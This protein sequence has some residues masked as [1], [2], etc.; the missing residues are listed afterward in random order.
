MK[1][2]NEIDG[3]DKVKQDSNNRFVTDEE[4][5]EWNNK[6]KITIGKYSLIVAGGLKKLI[7]GGMIV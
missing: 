7:K 4:K 3:A 2:L 1:F 6:A 5:Q